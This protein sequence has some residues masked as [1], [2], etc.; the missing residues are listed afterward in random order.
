M[1]Y[2]FAVLMGIVQ[3]ITEFL[4]FSSSGI[5]GVLERVS[6]F[7]VPAILFHAFVHAGTMAAIALTMRQDVTQ[8]F[9][10]GFRVNTKRVGQLADY[11][12]TGGERKLLSRSMAGSTNQ[13]T[14]SRMIAGA[15]IPAGI[16]GFI[17]ERLIAALSA[18]PFVA[19]I[20]FLASGIVLLVTDKVPPGNTMPK[21]VPSHFTWVIGAAAGF[22]LMPGVSSTAVVMCACIFAGFNR[23]TAIRFA[24]LLSVPLTAAAWI[25]EI[26]RGIISRT[27]TLEGLLCC[28]AGMLA[29]GVTGYMVMRPLAA[30]L[31]RNNLQTSAHISFALGAVAILTGFV[32]RY[33][34]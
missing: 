3:G 16:M 32:V 30:Y 10:E 1:Y 29:A 34:A 23:K 14:F 8:L 28:V 6:G 15:V 11:L 19:G 21:D 24:L 18:S 22:A 33:M 20:G 7:H 25:W 17:L 13:Q 2:L 27:I 31:R 12:N 9:R 4:P 26:L 5:M